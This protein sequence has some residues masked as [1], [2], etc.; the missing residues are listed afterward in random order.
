MEPVHA[1]RGPPI[2]TAGR[3][4]DRD[5]VVLEHEVRDQV[6][7]DQPGEDEDRVGHA[8]PA[9]IADPDGGGA[10]ALDPLAERARQGAR[11]GG[12][13]PDAGARGDHRHGRPTHAQALGG[14]R[15][16]E[17]L[18]EDQP[19]DLALAV[20]ELVEQRTQ[21]RAELV[22]E[23]VGRRVARRRQQAKRGGSWRAR[24]AR[25]RRGTRARSALSRARTRP[26]RR[27]RR[28]PSGSLARR[29][30]GRPAARPGTG[31]RPA[32]AGAGARHPG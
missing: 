14:V 5:P 21:D 23:R 10:R 1:E 7:E 8:A 16:P 27:P 9:G 25:A 11:Q 30:A 28:S 18:D 20:G 26:A 12:Q 2:A 6:R 17:V 22:Q 15:A 24:A 4:V 13:V 31:R 19:R 32:R 29:R 3:L